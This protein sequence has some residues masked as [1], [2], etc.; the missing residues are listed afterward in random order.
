MAATAVRY[1]NFIDGAWADSAERVD[2]VQPGDGRADRRL[3]RVDDRRRGPRG[4]GGEGG[5]RA[6]AAGAGAEARGD[7]LPGRGADPRPQG[8]PLAADDAGDGQGAAGGAWRCPGGHRHDVLHGRRGPAAV[9]PDGAGG[10]ARQVRRCRCAG[11][12]ASS[13]RSRPG[14]SRWRSRPGRSCR[15]SSPATRSSSSR[16]RTRRCWRPSWSRSS[17]R[18]ACPQGVVNMVYGSG[19]T[20]GEHL[21]RHPDVPVVSF[22]GSLATGRRVN[23]AGAPLLKRIAPRARRQER[24]HRAGRTPTSTTRSTASSGAPSAPSGQRC[25]AAEPRDRRHERVHDAAA[26]QARGARRG[27]APR[28][29]PRPRDRRRPGHQPQGRRQD[30]RLR[31]RRRAASAPAR[32]RAV[33]T[34]GEIARD[35]DLGARPLLPPDGV[36]RRRARACASPRRRSSGR[37][38]ASSAAT[39]STTRCAIANGIEYGLSSAIYTARREQ[40]PSAR[41]ATSTPASRTSTPA[42]RAPRCTCPFGGV[43]AHRQ[44]PPRG[45][46]G[47]ARH[48]HRVEVDLRRLLRHAAARPDRQPVEEGRR[49][50]DRA[51]TTTSWRSAP[52]SPRSCLAINRLESQTFDLVDDDVREELRRLADEKKAHALVLLGLLQRL[53]P[54]FAGQRG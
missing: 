15:R 49:A 36:R 5:L 6:L 11:R 31:E 43:K 20:V 48:V 16:P 3:R 37:S 32:A 38:R 14:T 28:R 47:R 19:A 13:P 34:G 54:K 35:G 45:G 41:C 17:T 33:L 21:V 39:A 52:T 22:T 27:A 12:W 18:R 25:T 30:R 8:G 53:D 42:R 50:P 4:R 9:R 46:D 1:G 24:D 26:V 40:R 29:R 2:D 44:R 23:E 10:D 7:P 51:R